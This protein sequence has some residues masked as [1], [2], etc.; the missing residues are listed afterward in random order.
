[1]YKSLNLCFKA[2]LIQ[3]F[4]KTK[5]V[6]AL[7]RSSILNEPRDEKTCLDNM[8]TTTLLFAAWIV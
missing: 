2:K 3:C 7:A 4:K 8:R 5:C 6:I 1:M